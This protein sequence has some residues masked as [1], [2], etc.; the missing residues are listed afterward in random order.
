MKPEGSLEY[1]QYLPIRVV[2]NIWERSPMQLVLFCEAT[3]ER[4]FP[5][6]SHAF[7][8]LTMG[9]STLYCD[10]SANE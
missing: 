7:M 5:L 10:I 3:N 6:P 2:A 8:A 4:P 9:S 1:S